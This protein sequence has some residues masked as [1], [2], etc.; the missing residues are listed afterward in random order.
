MGM[1]QSRTLEAIKAARGRFPMAW[2]EIHPDNGSPFINNHVHAY[3]KLEQQLEF[4]RS[5]PYKKN[6]LLPQYPLIP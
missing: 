2:I 6:R 3:M 4:S 1:G 5:R